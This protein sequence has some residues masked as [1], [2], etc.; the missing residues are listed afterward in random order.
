MKTILIET[1]RNGWLIRP[2]SPCERWVLG[3]GL[4]MAVYNRLEELQADL[5][6]LLKFEGYE[7][8]KDEDAKKGQGPGGTG[9]TQG[10]GSETRGAA[11]GP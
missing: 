10:P 6:K 11:T 9:E 1:V 8:V 4:E 7:K 3:E 2:F 5:P